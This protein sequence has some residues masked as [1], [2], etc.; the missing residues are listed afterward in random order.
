[1]EADTLLGRLYREKAELEEIRDL[2][3]TVISGLKSGEISMER[4][5]V[6]EQGVH[7]KPVR[8]AD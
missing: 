6:T 1:M 8:H 5:E 7:L 3:I 4:V 2:L